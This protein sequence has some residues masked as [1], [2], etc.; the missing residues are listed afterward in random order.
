MQR[1]MLLLL[2]AVVAVVGLTI[3][4]CGTATKADSK[5]VQKAAREAGESKAVQEA[6]EAYDSSKGVRQHIRA[7]KIQHSARAIAEDY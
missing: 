3:A 5:G 7:K 6:R 2:A 1:K 4:G